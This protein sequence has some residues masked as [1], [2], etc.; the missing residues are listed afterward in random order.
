MKLLIAAAG[1]TLALLSAATQFPDAPTGFDN[2]TNGMVDEVTHQADQVKFEEVEEV[3]E[4]L[5][6]LYNAQSCRECHQN[7]ISGGASPTSRSRT[8]PQ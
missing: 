7:P 8:E 3:S 2:K 6:P 4:G 1:Y 5:G